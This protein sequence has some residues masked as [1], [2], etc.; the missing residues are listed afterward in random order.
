MN[1]LQLKILVGM[2]LAVGLSIFSYK[3]FVLGFPLTPKEQTEI[4]NVEAHVSFDAKE[5]P[6]KVTLQ[7]LN[8]IPGF[9]VT[10]EYFI[11]DN[12]GLL[13]SLQTSEG[14]PATEEDS[15]NAVAVW[16]RRSAKGKQDLFYSA[17]LRPVYSSRDTGW[18]HPDRVPSL[19]DPHFTD[20]ETVAANSLINKVGKE[21]ADIKTYVPMLMNM[22]MHPSENKN[23]AYLLRDTDTLAGKVNMAVR[24]LHFSGIPAQAV[25]GITLGISD[26]AQL[27][28]WLELY[29]NDS[30]HMFDVNRGTFGVPVHFVPW[31]RGNAPLARVSG[32]SNLDVT[33][34]VTPATISSLGNVV[35]QLTVTSPTILEFS[36]FNLPVQAQATYRVILL[37]PIGVLLLVFLRNVIGVTTFGTF[38]PVLI[39]LSFRE[40]Q[41]VW[42]LCL[43]S[44]VI[45]LGLAVRLYLEHLKLL[46]VPRLASVLI[47]V[48][49][50]M[51]G[52][53][54]VSFK[55]GFPRGI[56]VSLFPMVI[57]SMTIERIS[58]VWDELGPAQAIRQIIGSMAVA[59]LAY[60]SMSSIYIEHLIFVFPEL[61]LVLLALTLTL[62]RY[63]GFRLL[64]LV[65]FRAL[66]KE[67]KA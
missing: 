38:M 18:V 50:L 15:G 61:F 51:A 63:T 44:I 5:A 22:L 56:S 39:A 62:G 6:V 35:D 26:D 11:G 36:L 17:R 57:M 52:I 3:V 21:S 48:V 34:S 25:H 54:V 1:S 45:M 67:N 58:I 13:N 59:V 10:N 53:S 60:L 40:T 7:T 19:T 41:L 8:R 46:L 12:Y 66:I 23:A 55:L 24:L 33:L 20:A 49:M 47:V 30:W 64:D 43:F 65:R 16:S 37:I 31:W 9:T 42:G 2:L 28:H 32:G 27:S 14:T 29:Q 4:W